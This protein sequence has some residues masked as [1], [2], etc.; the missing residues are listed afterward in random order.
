MLQ[1]HPYWKIRK[2]IKKV[3]NVYVY[4]VIFYA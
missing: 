3:Y 1:K 2:K 4:F